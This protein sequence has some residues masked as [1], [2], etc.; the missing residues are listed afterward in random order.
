MSK[1]FW[2]F[3]EVNASAGD[4]WHNC[5]KFAV[6]YMLTHQDGHYEFQHSC[7]WCHKYWCG[8]EINFWLLALVLYSVTFTA[9]IT[10]SHTLM[11]YMKNLLDMSLECKY[12]LW[13]NN[14]NSL[15]HAFSCVSMWYVYT[16][17][18]GKVYLDGP[19]LPFNS[20]LLSAEWKWA[21]LLLVWVIRYR[22][23][24]Y[25]SYISNFPF[26]RASFPK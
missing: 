26:L 8:T 1:H 12:Y 22:Q 7:L 2:I 21:W 23:Y 5:S 17:L 16:R 15:L 4:I 9:A 6:K 3:V 20:G 24:S 11:G 14:W 10:V 13:I 18:I 25:I 19:Y